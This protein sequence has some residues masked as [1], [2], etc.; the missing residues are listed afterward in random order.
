MSVTCCPF[1]RALITSISNKRKCLYVTTKKL[2]QPQAGS[3]NLKSPIFEWNSTSFFGV[4]FTFSNSLQS[5]SKNK[6]FITFNIF[7]SLV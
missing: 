3:K 6:G 7:F 4:A 5:S 1:L 2:P